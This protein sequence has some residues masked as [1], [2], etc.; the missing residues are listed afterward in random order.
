MGVLPSEAARIRRFWAEGFPDGSPV[1]AWHLEVAAEWDRIGETQKDKVIR[2]YQKLLDGAS[3]CLA[4]FEPA[5]ELGQYWLNQ[6]LEID[7]K[8]MELDP[9]HER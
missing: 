8:L 6:I 4:R 9:N 1:K 2:Q 3:T 7:A 5:S